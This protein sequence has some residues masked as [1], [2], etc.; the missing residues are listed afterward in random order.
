MRQPERIYK[1]EHGRVV[2]E[3]MIGHYLNECIAL[4]LLSHP[5]IVRAVGVYECPKAQRSY[6]LMEFAELGRRILW[7]P[8]DQRFAVS[9]ECQATH[10]SLLKPVFRAIASAVAHCELSRS[11]QGRLPRGLEARQR[12]VPQERRAPAD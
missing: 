11:R 3:T 4:S 5:H 1:D 12:R 8:A 9:P 10:F 2:K 6:L 7:S